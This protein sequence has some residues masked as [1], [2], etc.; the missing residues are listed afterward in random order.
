MKRRVLPWPALPV[1]AL[2]LVFL[3]VLPGA[4]VA[5]GLLAGLLVYRFRT[6]EEWFDLV[7]DSGRIIG[8]APRSLVHGRPDLLHPVVPLHVFSS[9]G[10]LLLQKRAP[11]KDVQPDKWDTAVGGHIARGESVAAALKRET[12]EELGLSLRHPVPLFRY[13]NRT[14][15]ES[16]LVH[17]FAMLHDGPFVPQASEISAVRFFDRESLSALGEAATPNLRE[18]LRLLADLRCFEAPFRDMLARGG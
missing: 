16:E 7:E 6:R 14:P 15:V 1:A 17:A 4:L 13:V 18:E 10:R 3:P 5:G 2:C 12:A 9:A 8:A 11:W